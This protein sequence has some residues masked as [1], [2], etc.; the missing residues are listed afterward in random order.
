VLAVAGCGGAGY[1]T[2]PSGNQGPMQPAGD[3]VQ[4]ATVEVQSN[5]FSPNTVLIAAGGTVTWTW[6]GSGH[7]VTSSGTPSFSP[8]APISNAP[9]TLGP[10]TFSTAGTYEYYCMVHG[11]AG[12]Y[13]TGSMTGAVF[14]R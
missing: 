8:S 14:V 2:N 9:N 4:A 1:G 12:A 10:I 3:P 6:I 7:S 5:Y 13:G 11:V